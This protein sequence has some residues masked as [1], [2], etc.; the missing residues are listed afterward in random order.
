MQLVARACLG[1]SLA[2]TLLEAASA[3]GP[4]H[5]LLSPNSVTDGVFATA[6]A[7]DAGRMM[8]GQPHRDDGSGRVYL[9]ERLGG[10]WSATATLTPSTGRPGDT[11]GE[12]LVLDGDRLVVGSGGGGGAA[13]RSGAAFVF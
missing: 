9:H 4:W 10:V 2:F 3:Q 12:A 1:G 7:L 5:A 6:V 13:Q 11:F 8:V